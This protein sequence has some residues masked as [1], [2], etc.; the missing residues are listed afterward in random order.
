MNK[1]VEVSPL[2]RVKRRL[3]TLQHLIDD[4]FEFGLIS[5]EDWQWHRKTIE[6]IRTIRIEQIL[7]EM[8]ENGDKT[9]N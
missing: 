4:S 5:K 3:I 6:E 8:E 9:G 2:M 7:K 1:E